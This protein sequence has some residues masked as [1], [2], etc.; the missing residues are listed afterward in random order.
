V[1]LRRLVN[2]T[3]LRRWASRDARENGPPASIRAEYASAL[4][5]F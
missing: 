5:T 3:L 1:K 2:E 4:I